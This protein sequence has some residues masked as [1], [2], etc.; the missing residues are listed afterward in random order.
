M[1]SLSDMTLEELWQ[2]FP[3]VLR[4]YD[5][6]WPTWYREESDSLRAALGPA[7][8]R[9]RHIGSTAVPGLVAKPTVDI[10]FELADGTDRSSVRTPIERLGWICMADREGPPPQTDFCKGYTPEGY[11]EKAYHL[12]VRP[13]GDWDEPVFRDYLRNHPDAAD[14]YVRLK[15]E[16]A[17]RF[18]NDRDA[19][20]E[21]KGGWIRRIV[22]LARYE[23]ECRR[24]GVQ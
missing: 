17:V 23:A 5:P 2:L 1:R 13:L 3:I 4:P 22:R 15:Q 19:Y 11:A 10:L 7:A 16:L 20:T 24:P 9:I 8:A 14:E 18:R 12:H 6:A 21:A